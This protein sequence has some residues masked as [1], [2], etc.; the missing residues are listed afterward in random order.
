[1][2][3]IYDTNFINW[4]LHRLDDVEVC[5]TIMGEIVLRRWNADRTFTIVSRHAKDEVAG[6]NALIT[7]KGLP[8]GYRLTRD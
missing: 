1:M 3:R 2:K 6:Y 4:I 5:K 7:L 8:A